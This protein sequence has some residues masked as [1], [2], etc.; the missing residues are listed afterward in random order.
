M[1]TIIRIGY[2]DFVVKDAAAA[3]KVMVVMAAAVPVEKCYRDGEYYYYPTNQDHQEISIRSVTGRHLLSHK[4]SEDEALPTDQAI[5]TPAPKPRR[6]IG[7]GTKELPWT[8]GQ[9]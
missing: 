6:R 2:N 4:P 8:G 3:S 9:S 7:T 1:P 5:I